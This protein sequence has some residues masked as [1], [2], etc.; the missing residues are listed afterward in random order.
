MLCDKNCRTTEKW[1]KS[2]G[3]ETHQ[4]SALGDL[5]LPSPHMDFY[6]TSNSNCLHNGPPQIWYLST[7]GM[8][9]LAQVEC[10]MHKNG[11]L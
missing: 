4:S 9:F 2:N 5:C 10:V 8:H 3:W 1:A 11:L 6:C 7:E